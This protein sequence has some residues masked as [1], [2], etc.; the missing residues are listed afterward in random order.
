MEKMNIIEVIAK[1]EK[2][3]QNYQEIIDNCNFLISCM[4]DENGKVL[5]TDKKNYKKAQEIKKQYEND[6]LIVDIMI[7]DIKKSLNLK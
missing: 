5:K 2:K 4:E 3:A 1:W 6:K 7:Y